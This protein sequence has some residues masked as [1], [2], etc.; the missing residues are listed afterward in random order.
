MAK[1]RRSGKVFVDWSQNNTAKTTV[2][3]YS[4]RARAA[5]GAPTVST[6]L[7]WDEVEGCTDAEELVFSPEGVLARIAEHGDI[8]ASA[9]REGAPLP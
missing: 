8:Y 7:T 6:P 4:L 9:L 2:A 5:H 1:D 3:P